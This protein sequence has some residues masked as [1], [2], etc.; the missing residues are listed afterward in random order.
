MDNRDNF[1]D[2]VYEPQKGSNNNS[3]DWNDN[4]SNN[5]GYTEKESNETVQQTE[6]V[7]IE[8]DMDSDVHQYNNNVNQNGETQ[9]G[10]D[11]TNQYNYQQNTGAQPPSYSN[12]QRG[13][14]P[15]PVGYGQ[16]PAGNPPPVGYG[17]P[18]VGNQPPVGYG[19][20]PVGN[21][22]PVGY[23]QPPV[24]NQPPVGYGQPPVG[25]PPPVG[26]GQPPV[27]SNYNAGERDFTNEQYG[28]NYESQNDRRQRYQ[29][30]ERPNG[31]YNNEEPRYYE[32]D[33]QHS[34]DYYSDKGYRRRSRNRG[35]KVFLYITS[36]VAMISAIAFFTVSIANI[37][38]N[39]GN[40]GLLGIPEDQLPYV[41]GIPDSSGGDDYSDFNPE[42]YFEFN[43]DDFF[44]IDPSD[45]DESNPF[46]PYIPDEG[47]GTTTQLPDGFIVDPDIDVPTNTQGVTIESE[48]LGEPLSPEEVYDKVSVSTVSV[49]AY[50]P[51]GIN[52]GEYTGGSGTGIIIT[53]DG[54]IL[55][56]SHV[57]GDKTSAVVK[58]VDYEGNEYPAVVVGVDRGT[59]LA[60]LKI[61]GNN[62]TPAEIGDSDELDMGQWVMAIGNPGGVEFSGS[63]TRGIVSGLER[64][65][66]YS[67]NDTMRYI[68][69]DAAIN[70]GNSGGPL[71]NMY[72]QV[73]GINTS[74]IVADDYEGMGFAIP[75]ANAKVILDQLLE[76]GY[77]GGRVR[78]GITAQNDYSGIKIV[79]IDEDSSFAGTEVQAG[80]I[81]IEVDGEDVTDLTA[82]SAKFLSYSPG[83]EV[84][85]VVSRSDAQGNTR[86]ITVTITL[87]EDKGETQK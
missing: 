60:V 2:D 10:V 39:Y 75:T 12:P 9:A 61:N 49:L 5:E 77:V 35:A 38:T 54:F 62:F 59:D 21:P 42:D 55:T 67:T 73:I 25:N 51:T 23:G 80:D 56:N 19:Q 28:V 48:P 71:V 37:V 24:G 27:E 22:P 52:E 74:K 85:V 87:L 86:D 57:V 40:R 83:D 44:G 58:I 47:S 26:Y 14:N 3:V 13:F 53:E 72:G 18:P 6:V 20:P 30:N 4:S 41:F 32:P 7:K 64:Q 81:I 68:Q 46:Y 43:P 50:V 11:V 79:A 16:P 70:P 31:G 65:V 84:E 45:P 36:V 78:L 8:T 34:G 69:T 82:L 66:G 29:T 63:I 15:P 17:Q 1:N 76:D 33:Y